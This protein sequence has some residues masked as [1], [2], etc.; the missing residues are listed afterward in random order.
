MRNNA[1]E[2]KIET[3]INPDDVKRLALQWLQD[4]IHDNAR[5]KGW[6]PELEGF[7]AEAA[8]WEDAQLFR[9]RINFGEKLALIHSEVSE[10]LE[11]T[12]QKESQQ[13]KH[14]PAFSNF[15]IE[16]ADAVIR[17]FD[18]AGACGIP[19]G[20]AIMAKM[21]ANKKRSFRHGNKKY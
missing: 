9:A 21:A 5:Q 2:E 13:D 11:A 12:R 10:A 20:S 15:A 8:D 16:L 14:C 19:L 6:W 3:R 4:E 18:L 1:V 7:D 17:C